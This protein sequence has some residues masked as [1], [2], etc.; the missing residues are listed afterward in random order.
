M[1]AVVKFPV[2]YALPTVCWAN[3]NLYIEEGGGQKIKKWRLSSGRPLLRLMQ[4]IFVALLASKFLQR[5]HHE[6]HMVDTWIN[7][8]PK[9]GRKYGMANVLSY[10]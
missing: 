8:P 4:A 2:N 5:L 3:S 1:Y 6:L 7:V 10:D 9:I